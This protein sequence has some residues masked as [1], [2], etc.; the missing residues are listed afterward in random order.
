MFVRFR[1]T[2]TGRRF[3]LLDRT[4]PVLFVDDDKILNNPN[5]VYLQGKASKEFLNL[6][7]YRIEQRTKTIKRL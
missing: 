4:N 1:D 6:H 7:G 2:N 3:Y 5:L